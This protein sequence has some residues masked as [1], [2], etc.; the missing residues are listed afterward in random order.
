MK[1]GTWI[2]YDEEWNVIDTQYY[3]NWK[4]VEEFWPTHYK[5][6]WPNEWFEK[7][8]EEW[9]LVL[10]WNYEDHTDYIFLTEWMREDYLNSAN[11]WEE[12][13]FKWKAYSVDWAA[14]SHYYNAESIEQLE[15][16]SEK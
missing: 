2:T 12:V 3:I 11:Y 5:I 7:E 6:I 1:D 14:W 13:I 15:A 4:L 16:V 9:T 10:R 8:T